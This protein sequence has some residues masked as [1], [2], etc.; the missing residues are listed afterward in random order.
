M[1]LQNRRDIVLKGDEGLATL[2]GKYTDEESFFSSDDK[3]LPGVEKH[4]RRIV[5]EGMLEVEEALSQM[6][7][8]A[9]LPVEKDT[10]DEAVYE[11]LGEYFHLKFVYNYDTIAPE[12]FNLKRREEVVV[13]I[14]KEFREVQVELPLFPS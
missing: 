9:V 8:E 7:Q 6:T 13:P 1:I 5:T 10:R 12:L 3:F 14:G 2:I 4:R 11:L